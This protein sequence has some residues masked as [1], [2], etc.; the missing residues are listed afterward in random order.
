[1]EES[2]VYGGLINIQTSIPAVC[3][4]EWPWTQSKKYK[5]VTLKNGKQ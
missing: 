2:F 4:D 5:A 1:M 3:S